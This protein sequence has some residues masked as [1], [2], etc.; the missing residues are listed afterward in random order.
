MHPLP[1]TDPGICCS[2]RLFRSVSFMIALFALGVLWSSLALRARWLLPVL[3]S[4]VQALLQQDNR[5]RGLCW[6]H[7]LTHLLLEKGM[8]L[9]AMVSLGIGLAV[10]LHWWCYMV[11]NMLIGNIRH[12]HNW[13]INIVFYIVLY[14]RFNVVYMT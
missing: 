12:V 13:Y 5:L 6:L 1:V 14:T 9:N 10:F 7:G 2:V 8:N 4:S 3:R 11:T